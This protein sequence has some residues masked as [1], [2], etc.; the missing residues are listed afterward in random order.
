MSLSDELAAR[1]ALIKELTAEKHAKVEL[2]KKLY[3]NIF[4]YIIIDLED[5][6]HEASK[7]GEVKKLT[8]D[9]H[10]KAELAKKLYSNIFRYLVLD[11]KDVIHEAGEKPEL[12]AFDLD[13]KSASAS[14]SEPKTTTVSLFRFPL[15][16]LLLQPPN[17]Q[18]TH[19]KKKD[20]K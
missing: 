14:V 5:V 9:K 17:H 18:H 10:A 16:H 6:I 8:A 11:L 3:D 2:A 20:E 1:D 7:K 15:W 12:D 19:E 13:E 4:R